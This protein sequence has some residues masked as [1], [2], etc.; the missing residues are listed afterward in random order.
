MPDTATAAPAAPTAA[1]GTPTVPA[2]ASTQPSAA[3]PAVKPEVSTSP[4]A[5]AQADADLKERAEKI[6]SDRKRQREHQTR[7][8]ELAKERQARRDAEKALAEAKKPQD[9]A[10]VVRALTPDQ[11]VGILR[12]LAASEADR[13]ALDE[14]MSKLPEPVR[15]V[16][17]AHTETAAKLAALEKDLADSK[18]WRAKLEKSYS[19]AEAKMQAKAV[20]EQAE[21]IYG[22]LM[23]E[24]TPED[25]GMLGKMK[26]KGDSR[27]RAAWNEVLTKHGADATQEDLP[28]LAKLAAKQA[29][30][31]A[32]S[33]AQD[34]RSLLVPTAPATIPPSGPG[35]TSPKSEDNPSLQQ[36]LAGV[37]DPRERRRIA[38]AFQ[39]GRASSQSP[40]TTVS[41]TPTAAVPV[42]GRQPGP[43]TLDSEY[44]GMS[45]RDRA[46]YLKQRAGR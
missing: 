46:R 27:L 33:E 18:E 43:A 28:L 9:A 12:D 29:R 38:A 13:Q 15:K 45:T 7:L 39:L 30:E 6:I 36:A 24:L 17:Q 2:P 44:A 16:V 23:G 14:A 1:T 41:S 37:I 11:Q 35:A 22:K 3:A 42:Q 8:A 40:A 4:P 31:M 10:S 21:T 5:P 26:D 25:L 20:A 19:E 32:E 34:W